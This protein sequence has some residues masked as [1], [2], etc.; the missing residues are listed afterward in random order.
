MREACTS[1]RCRR[2]YPIAERSPRCIICHFLCTRGLEH[3]PRSS[4]VSTP[5]DALS[6]TVRVRGACTPSRVCFLGRPRVAF[7][8]VH[9]LRPPRARG[10]VPH[11]RAFSSALSRDH[12]DSMRMFKARCG[13][14]S[15]RGSYPVFAR[16]HRYRLET[17]TKTRREL[18]SRCS[19]RTPLQRGR[20]TPA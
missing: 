9:H 17:P 11:V 1:S 20:P 6:G 13:R 15:V 10:I 7:V 5:P 19:F 3:V 16:V 18:R 14:L 2:P 4:A 8:P 12:K